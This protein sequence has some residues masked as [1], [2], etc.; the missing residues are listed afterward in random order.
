MAWSVTW[1][2]RI[3]TGSE[4]LRTSRENKKVLL[5]SDG[6]WRKRYLIQPEGGKLVSNVGGREGEG[7]SAESR[8]DIN[9]HA[10]GQVKY[11]TFQQLQEG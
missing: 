3:K 11:G 4:L 5:L 9:I 10:Q 1:E 2:S 7:R 8:K 6:W